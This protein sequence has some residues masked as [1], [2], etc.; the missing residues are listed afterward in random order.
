[1]SGWIR[2]YSD[3][4]TG[5]VNTSAQKE[6]REHVSPS[7]S[8]RGRRALPASGYLGKVAEMQI[9][10]FHQDAL[11]QNLYRGPPDYAFV[12]SSP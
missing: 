8:W 10:G 3:P 5:P 9:P 12:I 4:V 2:V 1:M 11:Y 7:V 6:Q